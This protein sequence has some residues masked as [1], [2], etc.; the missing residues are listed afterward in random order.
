[1][2]DRLREDIDLL[3][4]AMQQYPESAT[5]RK[6]AGVSKPVMHDSLIIWV[7]Y[8]DEKGYPGKYVLRPFRI[9]SG[10][11]FPLAKMLVLDSLEEARD[12]IPPGLARIAP[13]PT[14][15]PEIVESWL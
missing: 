6:L 1:M 15:Q 7:I 4:L 9:K 13:D 5:T 10:I 14:D 8:H 3:P 2:N 12:V 11:S